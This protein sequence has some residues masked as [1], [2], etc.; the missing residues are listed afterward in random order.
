MA[1][2]KATKN[3]Q[4]VA[5]EKPSKRQKESANPEPTGPA[6]AGT[7]AGGASRTASPGAR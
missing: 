4:S 3:A 1:K 5:K 7:G 6:S 2:R